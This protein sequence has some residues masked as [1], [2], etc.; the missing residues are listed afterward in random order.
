MGVRSWREREKT[1]RVMEP[2]KAYRGQEIRKRFQVWEEITG[3]NLLFPPE[4][5]TPEES[6]EAQRIIEALLPP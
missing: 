3:R 1:G 4:A 6:D 2:R 5:D